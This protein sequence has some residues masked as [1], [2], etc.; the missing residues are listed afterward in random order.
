LAG[1]GT[2]MGEMTERS[3]GRAFGL[4]G[5]ILLLLG[6]LLALVLGT[7]ELVVGR[8]YTAVSAGSEGIVLLVI[9]VIALVFSNLASG[10]WSGRPAVSGVMLMVVSLVAW[11]TL[12]LGGNIVALLGAIL[13]FLAG[14]LYLVNPALKAVGSATAS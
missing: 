1:L 4:L 12:G 9:G 10:S 11:V 5:G 13:V 6:G 14:V 3:L 2:N 7:A 8:P